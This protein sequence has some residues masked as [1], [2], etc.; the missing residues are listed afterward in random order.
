[1]SSVLVVEDDRDVRDALG[2]VLEDE[3][4]EVVMAANGK[5]ALGLLG[6]GLRPNVVLLDLMM[7]I[8]SG[9]EMR[10][11]MLRDPGIADIP[12]I[13][14]TGDTRAA[15]RTADLRVVAC[16]AKPF[17]VDDLL[18]KVAELAPHERKRAA[19]QR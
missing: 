5:E 7:P 3:G 19:G 11:Q 18:D 15:Q 16:I 13:V 9:W 12:T 8:M 4:Y 1:V 17:E 2:L 14:I 10:E 6:T